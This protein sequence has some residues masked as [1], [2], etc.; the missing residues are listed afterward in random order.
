MKKRI[1]AVAAAMAVAAVMMF[2]GTVSAFAD[3]ARTANVEVTM[4]KD[5][6]FVLCH[7]NVKV[8][9][10]LSDK[11]GLKDNCSGVSVLDVMLAM[12]EEYYGGKFTKDSMEDYFIV[13]EDSNYVGYGIYKVLG[14]GDDASALS[15]GYYVNDVAAMSTDDEVAD[16]AKFDLFI[17]QDT[18]AYSDM[19]TMFE[20][21]SYEGKNGQDI[22]V[23]LNGDGHDDSWNIVKTPVAGADLYVVES[24]KISEEPI[25]RTDDNGEA[26]VSFKNAGV[27]NLTAK[28]KEMPIVMPWCT[29]TVTGDEDP[30]IDPSEDPS[31]DPSQ[32]PT[33]DQTEHKGTEA[34]TD[35]KSDTAK[36]GD[37]SNIM[38]FV[39]IAAAAAVCGGVTVFARRKAH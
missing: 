39:L 14:T 31:K 37:D 28:Y 4:Q 13:K 17:Y 11:Y 19:Y 30:V 24:G 3:E 8:S 16:G 6:R 38:I 36:T 25:A 33:S 18:T 1:L 12:H 23:K 32:D 5:Y 20:S 29:V 34:S 35:K 15:C 10:D 22:T 27:Y 9:S 21:S 7:K 2:G 26:V